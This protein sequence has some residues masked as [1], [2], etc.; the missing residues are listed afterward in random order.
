MCKKD[1]PPPR[2]APPDGGRVLSRAKARSFS[3]TASTSSSDAGATGTPDGANGTSAS[4]SDSAAARDSAPGRALVTTSSDSATQQCY[5]SVNTTVVG[6]VSISIFGVVWIAIS[7]VVYGI[8]EQRPRV[9]WART[10][11]AES[12]ARKAAEKHSSVAAAPQIV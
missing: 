8:V 5:A 2:G 7:A 10:P 11:L 3:T 12:R 6:L 1:R 4:T 9:A